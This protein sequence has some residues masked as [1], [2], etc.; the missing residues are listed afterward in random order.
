MAKSLI[1]TYDEKDESI[2]MSFL[3]KLKIS[4]MNAQKQAIQSGLWDYLDAEEKEDFV[5]GAMIMETNR[6][7]TVDTE[8]FKRELKTSHSFSQIDSNSLSKS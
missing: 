8:N 6:A 7:H 4:T 3:K 5:F 2:L 1:I